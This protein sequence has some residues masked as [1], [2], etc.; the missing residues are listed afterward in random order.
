[1]AQGVLF[2]ATDEDRR[3]VRDMVTAGIPHEGIAAALRD[4]VSINTLYKHFRRELDIAHNQSI[5]LAAGKLM[6]AVSRGEAWAICFFLKCRG[7]WQE[8]QAIQVT[9]E[10]SLVDVLKRREA[11]NGGPSK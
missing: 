3:I 4:G 10:V 1:M 9:G 2:K 7:G 11:K 8:R 5:G 6:T